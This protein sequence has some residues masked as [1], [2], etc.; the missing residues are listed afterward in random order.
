[1]LRSTLSRGSSAAALML[2]IAVSDASAQEALP[3]IDIA[4]AQNNEAPSGGPS[5][6]GTAREQGYVV[7]N[8]S[9]ATKMNIPNLQLPA[10]VKVVPREAI[11]DQAATSVKDA[12][13]NVSG[14]RPNQT[15][16]TGSRY[17][18]RGFADAGKI[19]RNGLR[20][21]SS[22]FTTDFGISNV[23]RI[24]VLKGP[25]SILYGRSEP[26]GLINIVTKR[27]VD[28]PIY[29]FEQRFGSY[30]HFFTSWDIA[31]SVNDEKS[32][33]YRF[34]GGY[35]NSGSFREFNHLERVHVNPS[36][37]VRLTP[38]TEFTVDVE[39]YDQDFT[40]DYGQ[41]AWGVR[42]AA[43]PVERSFA[44]PNQP[45]A[46][47][48]NVYVGS[49]FTHRF[50]E[51]FTF[52]NR[53]L[54]SFLHGNSEFLNPTSLLS[55]GVL[56]RTM[57]GQWNDSDVYSTNF[58]LQGRF[59]LLGA[60]HEALIGFDYLNQREEYST[61][62]SRTTA[63]ANYDINIFSPWS[64]Y[65]VASALFYGAQWY[66]P[67]YGKDR[68]VRYEEQKGAY[69]Q[70]HITLFD[71]LHILG[72]GRY[73]WAETGSAFGTSL[74]EAEANLQ[75]SVP[76]V[77]RRDGAFS[78]RVGILYQL[79][80][81]ASVY[82]SWTTSFG[83]NNGVDKYYQPHPP[84][85]SEQFEVGAKAELFDGRLTT[86]L[87][88]FHLDKTN[89]LTRDLSSSD[90]TVTRAIG[91]QR[92][93]G[94]EFDVSGKLLN[95]VSVLGSFT[96]M[97]ARVTKD[98]TL[99]SSGNY[100]TLGHRLMNIPRYSGSVWLKWDVKEI[101]ELD[102]F[103]LGFG[104]FV[105][106]NRQGDSTSTFQ[107]PGYVRL[108]ALAAYKWKVGPTNVTAQLNLRNLAN[109]RYYESTDPSSNANPRFAIYPGAPFTA[110]GSIKVEF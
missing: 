86:S 9:T 28:E 95:D 97:D 85:Q 43:I 65:G 61:Y 39:Y 27:P 92:S 16:G 13:E 80:P 2:A 102:G 96:Y 35:V 55:N 3:A 90:P 56:K 1:M 99:D 6:S 31:D 82:G 73:D 62:G 33:L 20:G 70:D 36:V 46:N 45:T 89:V 105:V 110:V 81:W 101:A 66:R 51:V 69:F 76:T 47:V 29:M 11:E 98:N 83:V 60:R 4:G 21:S 37:T 18:I 58:D 77:V 67:N 87:A 41:P 52:K 17:Y 30:S 84:Q 34:S 103:S 68:S 23:E 8:T 7:R 10:S 78:P 74:S 38:D 5:S 59:D 71:R 40:A 22:N 57:F 91:K 44:D 14:V 15:L 19:Y 75:Y 50:N 48:R 25:A 109:T 72:G 107:L 64:S 26:G 94:V 106:G 104:A 79:F 49:E 93:K 54:A 88:F 100:T 108:D 12:L 42:P 53:F 63:T 32:V 24:E